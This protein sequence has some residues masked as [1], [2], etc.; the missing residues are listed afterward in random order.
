M[1][2][3]FKECFSFFK[4]WFHSLPLSKLIKDDKTITRWCITIWVWWA[5]IFYIL[6][7]IDA[8][9]LSREEIPISFQ[10]FLLYLI[11]SF[12]SFHF[13]LSRKDEIVE[14]NVPYFSSSTWLS[15]VFHFL[16]S[17]FLIMIMLWVVVLG[18]LQQM[19]YWHYYIRLSLE[20]P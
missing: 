15:V 11:L 6:L 3:K 1:T 19:I 13:S 10:L 14:T 9:L 20:V 18:S 7:A 12:F 5:W 17:Q 8:S 4:S 2:H 16:Q